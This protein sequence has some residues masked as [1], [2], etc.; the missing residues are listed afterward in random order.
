MPASHDILTRHW[1]E[2]TARNVDRYSEEMVRQFYASNV[3]TFRSQLDRQATP[4]K[5]APLE[6]V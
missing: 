5:Q 2:W 3:A 4:A 6:Y 1:L